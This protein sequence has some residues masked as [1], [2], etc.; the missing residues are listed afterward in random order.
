MVQNDIDQT[1]EKIVELME[2]GEWE[3]GYETL[4]NLLGFEGI[5]KEQK[6]WA[7]DNLGFAS[8]RLEKF[9]EALSCCDTVLEMV[10]SHAYALKGRGL[11]L[12][13][14]GK[15]EE[16]IKSLLQAINVDPSFFDAYHD[17]AVILISIGQKAEAKKWA[18]RAY[19]IDPVQGEALVSQFY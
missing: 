10:P 16:G 9:E 8:Y 3:S 1:M 11:V 6:I 18:Q 15:V 5:K 17:L 19:Q 13:E 12:A 7:L 4:K 14:L 2:N